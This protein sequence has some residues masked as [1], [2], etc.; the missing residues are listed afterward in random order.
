VRFT[1]NGPQNL[2]TKKWNC[3]PIMEK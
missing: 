1:Y 2:D 3:C